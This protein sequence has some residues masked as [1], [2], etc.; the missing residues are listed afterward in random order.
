M[1]DDWTARFE[2][3][4]EPPT[5]KIQANYIATHR[6]AVSGRGVGFTDSERASRLIFDVDREA[7]E[8]IFRRYPSTM[9]PFRT[10]AAIEALRG[11][12]V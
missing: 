4:L 5:T 8:G 3:V 12:G 10:L 6:S 9:H 7:R 2:L 1:L 11:F